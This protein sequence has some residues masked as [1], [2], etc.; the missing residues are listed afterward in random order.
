MFQ[1]GDLVQYIGWP[2]EFENGAPSR[3]SIHEVRDFEM[4]PYPEDPAQK[5]YPWITLASLVGWFR[6]EAFRL[7]SRP[8]P[9]I[10]QEQIKEPAFS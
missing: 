1:K 10:M 9:D 2:T 5:P 4:S 8:D 6:A 3:L 7:I